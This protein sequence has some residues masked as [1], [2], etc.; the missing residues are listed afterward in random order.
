MHRLHLLGLNHT[1]APL[2]VRERLAFAPPQRAAAMAE[3]GRQFPGCEAVLL[4]TCNRV[5]MYVARTAG[6]APTVGDVSGFLA[7]YHGIPLELFHPHLYHRSDRGMVEHLFNVAASLDSMVLGETQILGQVRE[8][9][10]AARA[11]GTAGSALNPLFQ[12]A[13]AV[14][15]QV[16]GQTDLAEG[17][18]SVAGAAVDYAGRVFDSLATKSVLCIGAGKMARLVLQAFADRSPKRLLVCNRDGDKAA[19][20]AGLFKGEAADFARLDDHLSAVDVVITSTGSAEPIITAQRF[21]AVHRRRRYRPIFLVDIAVPRDVEA[22]VGELENVYLCNLDDLH[23]AVAETHAGRQESV[24]DARR[25]VAAA[26][27]EYVSDHRARTLGPVIDALFKRS[28]QLARE[29]LERSLHKLP[30]VSEAERQHLE[31]LT[32]RIV[33]KLLHDPVR[34][35][36]RAEGAHGSQYVH[37]MEQLFGL[38]ATEPDKTGPGT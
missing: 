34:A 14:G 4:S 18:H 24:A 30:N 25:I 8:A 21:S 16:L 23:R 33:N 10:D 9:Y 32:R 27:D 1:T 15:R 31:E 20:L 35:L 37:A 7:S 19:E 11:A 36:R 29:E 2:A 26:V 17:R 3:F 5:E 38:G 22:A 6:G 13:V 12:R 28:H